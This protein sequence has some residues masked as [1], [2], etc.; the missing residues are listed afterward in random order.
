MS[1]ATTGASIPVFMIGNSDGIAISAQYRSGIPVKMTITP[2]GLN[3]QRDLGF[4]PDG[5]AGWH[6]YAV[7][8]DQLP[9]GVATPAPYKC[10]D[11]A[12]IANYG[13]SDAINVEL[14][15]SLDYTPD[16]TGIKTNLHKDTLSGESTFYGLAHIPQSDSIIAM[17]SAPEYSFA[18]A[19][20]GTGRYDLTYTIFSDSVDQYPV[21][22]TTTLSFYTTDSVYSKGR[23]DFTNKE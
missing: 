16:A 22:N 20:T 23:Y 3:N 21:D 7:P 9:A 10:L 19:V 11:G 5:A 8:K 17:F 13:S 18:P 2:W 12:F 14:A 15:G 4:V 6:A 1:A